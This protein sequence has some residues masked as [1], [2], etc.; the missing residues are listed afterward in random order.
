MKTF[1]TTLAALFLLLFILTTFIPYPEARASADAAGFSTSDI[2]TGLQLTFERRF[3]FW[4]ATLVELGLLGTFALT[5]VGRRWADRLLA[6]TGHRRILAALLMGLSI[7]IVHEALWLP[8]GIA[9]LYHAKAWGMSNLDVLDWFVD[10]AKS[11]AIGLIL[12]GVIVSGLYTVLILFP[13][14]WWLLAAVGSAALGVAG[15]FLAPVIITPLFNTFTPLGETEWRDHGPRVE[16]LIAKAGIPIQQILVVDGSRQSNHTNAYF[17]GFGATRRIVLYDTLFKKNYTADE[18][19]S[20]LAHEIGHW[21][22]DHI[23]KGMLLG[24]LAALAGFFLLDRTLRLAVARAPWNLQSIADP[25]GLPLLMLLFFL[26]NWA[27][28][29]AYNGVSR[30]FEQ[31]ADGWSLTLA[32]NPEAFIA[33]ERKLARDN[34]ANV[35]PTPWN[36]WLF[37]T[38][39]PTV[40]R[41]RMAEE[42]RT[43]TSQTDS[44]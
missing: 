40:E 34:K 10:H 14:A 18:I 21:R 17:T 5:S 31:Q 36:V 33:C 7:G 1:V 11:S 15:A 27:M 42:W 2:D 41:I 25:A 29:P 12:G 38:H 3:F 39:P 24:A 20:I 30:H 28:L 8:I 19:E 6:W 22:E 44:K 4:A 13:R 9:R 26:G 23:N 43:R 35:A 37:A 32:D 16:A